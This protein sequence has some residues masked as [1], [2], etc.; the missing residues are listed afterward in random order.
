M[1]SMVTNIKMADENELM[2]YINFYFFG[3]NLTLSQKKS[4]ASSLSLFLVEGTLISNDVL[5]WKKF[6]EERDSDSWFRSQLIPE[7]TSLDILIRGMK[8]SKLSLAPWL[9]SCNA[10][11]LWTSHHWTCTDLRYTANTTRR[12]KTFKDVVWSWK[13]KNSPNDPTIVGWFP[14]A[15]ATIVAWENLK[16]LQA[17][18]LKLNYCNPKTV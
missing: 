12:W 18:H 1:V 7:W 17:P 10:R 14:S 11:H 9:L 8:I 15:S 6:R 13:K 3:I 4:S 5:L 2:K 16:I